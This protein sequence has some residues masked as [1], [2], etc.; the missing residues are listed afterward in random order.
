MNYIIRQKVLYDDEIRDD[1]IHPMKGLFAESRQKAP[2]KVGIRA[3][4]SFMFVAIAIL[5]GMNYHVDQSVKPL[6]YLSAC[7]GSSLLYLSGCLKMKMKRA[8]RAHEDDDCE[9]AEVKSLE[10][11]S[12]ITFAISVVMLLIFV[13]IASNYVSH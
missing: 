3:L 4:I 11:R 10:R 5:T 9:S 8:K 2:K 7:M 6:F 12:K 13:N 1:K